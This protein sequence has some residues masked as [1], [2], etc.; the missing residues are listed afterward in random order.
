M[1]QLIEW[2]E[3]PTEIC[4]ET[5]SRNVETQQIYILNRIET[6]LLHD[7]SVLKSVLGLQ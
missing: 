3:L 5:D 2:I 7:R 4:E 6:G 1:L